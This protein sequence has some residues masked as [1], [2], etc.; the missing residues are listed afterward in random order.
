ML[1][2]MYASYISVIILFEL[3]SLQTTLHL[4]QFCT[5]QCTVNRRTLNQ[6]KTY[7]TVMLKL[8]QENVTQKRKLLE[9][10]V[11]LNLLGC[12]PVRMSA[13]DT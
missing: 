10:N 13:S 6:R 11:D 3:F 8:G 5:M 9:S 4:F 7:G 2:V 1:F 12:H